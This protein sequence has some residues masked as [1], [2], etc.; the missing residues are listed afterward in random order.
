MQPSV[1]PKNMSGKNSQNI[2]S[3]IAFG[4]VLSVTLLLV[5]FYFYN[6]VEWRNYPDFG[7]AFR[8]ATGIDSVGMVNR[9]GSD[10]GL[11]IGIES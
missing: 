11:K 3:W 8:T 4:V 2:P 10:A 1:P 5:G 6:L 7:F 9:H